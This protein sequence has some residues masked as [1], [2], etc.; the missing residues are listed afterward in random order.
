MDLFIVLFGY[1]FT[2]LTLRFPAFMSFSYFEWRPAAN[3]RRLGAKQLL[4]IWPRP[5][6]LVDFLRNLPDAKQVIN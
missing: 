3:W 4:A 5:R 1:I 2:W 6:G